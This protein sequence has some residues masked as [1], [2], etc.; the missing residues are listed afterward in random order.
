[1]FL[2]CSLFARPNFYSLWGLGVGSRLFLITCPK[3]VLRPLDVY[4]FR[5]LWLNTV[6][7]VHG[8]SVFLY[9]QLKVQKTPRRNFWHVNVQHPMLGGKTHSRAVLTSHLSRTRGSK[10]Q[11]V[12]HQRYW[13]WAVS[14]DLNW[15]IDIHGNLTYLYDTSNLGSWNAHW[16]QQWLGLV[17]QRDGD[18]TF[19]RVK[20]GALFLYN[21]FI[22][23]YYIIGFHGIY[24]WYMIYTTV[25]SVKKHNSR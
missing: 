24:V 19:A 18:A 15:S 21:Y 7:L 25:Q 8:F 20:L 17:S 2:I 9:T 23:E 5:C 4:E 11:F 13:R 14:V 6:Q 22:S 1:M 16:W 3:A 10:D 12:W